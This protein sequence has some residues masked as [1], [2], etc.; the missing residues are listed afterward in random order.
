MLAGPAADG[1]AKLIRDAL[2][3]HGGHA[4]LMRGAAALRASID[5][6]DPL[7]GALAALVRRVKDSFDPRHVLNPGRMYAG[8]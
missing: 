2:R 6:F 1:G 5:V 8:I 7:D 4:T 3:I